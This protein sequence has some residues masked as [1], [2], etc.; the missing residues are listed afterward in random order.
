MPEEVPTLK[1]P[2]RKQ[3]ESKELP[4]V[5][6]KFTPTN[7]NFVSKEL[8]LNRQNAYH[9]NINRT[10]VAYPQSN[11]NYFAPSANS[12][13][14]P[15]MAVNQHVLYHTSQEAAPYWGAGPNPAILP[16]HSRPGMQQYEGVQMPPVSHLYSATAA[17]APAP[18]PV[19]Y[20]YSAA[21]VAPTPAAPVD[22]ASSGP[23]DYRQL[24]LKTSAPLQSQ[25]KE[26]N[27]SSISSISS[28][29]QQSQ[30]S[31]LNTLGV[32]GEVPK[33]K[34]PGMAPPAS[35][36]YVPKAASQGQRSPG[37]VG[38]NNQ[39]RPSI[40]TASVTSQAEK[41]INSSAQLLSSSILSASSLPDPVPPQ[42]KGDTASNRRS[43]ASNHS[44]STAGHSNRAPSVINARK[45]SIASSSSQSSVSSNNSQRRPPSVIISDGFAKTQSNRMSGYYN[46]NRQSTFSNAQLKYLNLDVGNG[47]GLAPP[48]TRS[49]ATSPHY[50]S[51]LQKSFRYSMMEVDEES[52]GTPSMERR[53]SHDGTLTRPK[54]N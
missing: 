19:N 27:A 39:R 5:P 49:T 9:S 31:S 46:P 53:H 13:R 20:L 8:P 16:G 44:A 40:S 11:G 25:R 6:L 38:G 33:P 3:T 50:A 7:S 26:S 12:S 17:P 54:K 18:A 14:D 29:P 4:T 23:I 28:G 51:P 37:V 42:P 30:K 52:A 47:P 45:S 1:W 48:S 10:S 35:N 22:Q 32:A 2:K 36:L 15:L 41:D 34:S 21:P 24:P 43:I